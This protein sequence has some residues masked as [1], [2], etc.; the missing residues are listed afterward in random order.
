MN[1]SIDFMNDSLMNGR[2]F[3]TFNVIDDYS[4]EVLAVEIS[5]STPSEHVVR[6][7]DQ[8]IDYRGKPKSIRMDN[9]PEFI[10]KTFELWCKQNNIEPRYIQ[11]G[12]PMQNGYVERFNGSYRRDVLDAYAFFELDEVRELTEK[13]MIDY[14]QN[15]PHESLN[16]KT[17][18][19]YAQQG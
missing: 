18:T 13:W 15:R 9:G 14:N 8:V 17:P 6:I 16:W 11:P 3:R 12:K 7:L 2:K 5:T 10:S 19:E 1:W 4:R